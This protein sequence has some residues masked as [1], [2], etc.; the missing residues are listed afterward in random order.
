MK[1]FNIILRV[2]SILIVILVFFVGSIFTVEVI[3]LFYDLN[4]LKAEELILISI[5]NS[6]YGILLAIVT[7]LFDKIVNYLWVVFSKINIFNTAHKKNSHDVQI[8]TGVNSSFILNNDKKT[9]IQFV[10]KFIESNY[11]Y[12]VFFCVTLI[13]LIF[14]FLYLFLK[15]M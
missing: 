7:I 12:Y 8:T 11:Y 4:A 15:W 9:A 2:T 1:I 14:N 10:I 6:I 13:V 5:W 3:S